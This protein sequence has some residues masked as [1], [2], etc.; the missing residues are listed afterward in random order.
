MSEKEHVQKGHPTHL[1]SKQFTQLRT[2]VMV[3]IALF[4]V[5]LFPI[6]CIESLGDDRGSNLEIF[7]FF[8]R[9]FQ[10]CY[11]EIGIYMEITFKKFSK[12]L[13]TMVVQRR[14]FCFLGPLKTPVSSF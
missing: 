6:G 5:F 7:S 9:N 8:L 14:K 4:T 3:Y 1:I 11:D 13:P 10:R 2:A 12:S